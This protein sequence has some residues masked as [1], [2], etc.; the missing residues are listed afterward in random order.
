[1]SGLMGVGR[2]GS[3]LEEVVM[4]IMLMLGWS[5]GQFCSQGG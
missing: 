2:V 5:D 3:M 1:M 4:M